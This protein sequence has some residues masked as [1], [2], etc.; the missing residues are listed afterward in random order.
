MQEYWNGAYGIPTAPVH[1]PTL[2]DAALQVIIVGGIAALVYIG[3][4][5]VTQ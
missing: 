2:G 3:Y 4:R 1:Q 5:L